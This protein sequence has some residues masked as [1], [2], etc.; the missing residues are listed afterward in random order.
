VVTIA[1]MRCKWLKSLSCALNSVLKNS[2]IRAS[3][4]GTSDIFAA[5]SE[6]EQ[7]SSEFKARERGRVL[8]LARLLDQLSFF[9]TLVLNQ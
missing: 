2:E 3:A 4:I 8:A 1:P 5:A 7:P 9:R 6:G